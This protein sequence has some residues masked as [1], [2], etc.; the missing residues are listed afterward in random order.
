[1][2]I[3]YSYRRFSSKKQERG[4]SLRRQKDTAQDWCKANGYL[5]QDKA[6]DD[7]GRSGF[8]GDN[9]QGDGALREFI[10]LHKSGSI[11]REALLLIDSVDRFS[12][13][14]VSK[15]AQYFLEVVNA[16]I[17]LVFTGSYD[18]RIVNQD[19]IDKEP[20]I[21]QA[22]IAELNRAHQES[23]EKSR[24]VKEAKAAKKAKMQA[25]EVVAHNNIPKYFSFKSGRYVHNEHTKLVLELV[26]GILAGKSLYELS[27]DLNERGIPTIRRKI[28]WSPPSV[29]AILTNRCLIGEYL[30]NAN[31]VPAIIDETKFL[32]VQNV[33]NQNSTKR[34]RKAQFTNVFNG[35]CFCADCGYSMNAWES[36]YKGKRFRYIRCSNYGKTTSCKKTYF[37]TD[38]VERDFFFNY[39]CKSLNDLVNDDDRAEVK[40]INADIAAK[41]AEL[42]KSKTAV[43]KV[44]ALLEDV[45][46][47][48]LKTKLLQLKSSQEVLKRDIDTLTAKLA[49]IQDAPQ[50]LGKWLVKVHDFDAD[51]V[52]TTYNDAAES[53]MEAL[54]DN[55]KRDKLRVMLPSLI[56]KVLM[57]NRT[58]TFSVLNRAGRTVYV[59][60]P[61]KSNNNNTEK[62]KESLKT[63]TKRK[64][65]NGKVIECKR[66]AY[67]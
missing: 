3:A 26:E 64:L 2:K 51:T 48:E 8:R 59:S 66:K 39:L 23:K 10:E 60:E 43:A 4:D 27:K 15:A 35:I 50:D 52:T 9:L 30:G 56:G 45:Q 38:E 24:K 46:M 21:L 63:W 41:T 17:R 19:L 33:L 14:P 16:G 20:Y 25:G 58:R 36:E 55:D 37:R 22:I 44:M 18:K 54:K 31:Y 40:A 57:H 28:Q 12:R 6:F 34:G 61:F 65:P 1:M 29:K 32:L 11:E 5:L 13:L 53:M 7:L 67:Q 62:W 49:A 42:N 47:D